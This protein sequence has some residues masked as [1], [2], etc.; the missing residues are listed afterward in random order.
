MLPRP[1]QLSARVLT[2]SVQRLAEGLNEVAGRGPERNLCFCFCPSS[3]DF[4]LGVVSPTQTFP[5]SRNPNVLLECGLNRMFSQAIPVLRLRKCLQLFQYFLCI[6]ISFFLKHLLLMCGVEG[7][8][9]PCQG[10]LVR[11][12]VQVRGIV[13][14]P[15]LCGFRGLNSGHHAYA[16]TS[17]V[18]NLSQITP[19]MR[20]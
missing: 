18:L 5:T 17:P 15:S 14:L 9:V 20:Q 16:A 3:S 1:V 6:Y 8:H 11:V 4:V 13:S 10:V 19:N 2:A 7:I 12:I